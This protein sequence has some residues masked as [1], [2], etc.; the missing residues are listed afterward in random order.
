MVQPQTKHINVWYDISRQAL[1]SGEVE[2]I[3]CPIE[4]MLADALTK[5]LCEVKFAHLHKLKHSV[6]SSLHICT[7]NSN[8]RHTRLDQSGS[9]EDQAS[10]CKR[11]A[12]TRLCINPRKQ[13][14]IQ[15]PQ[16]NTAIHSL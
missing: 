13:E 6:K 5:A 7:I 8:S 3:Y 12:S 16:N 4:L 14:L 11:K 15:M 9:V 1:K 10:A 2:L